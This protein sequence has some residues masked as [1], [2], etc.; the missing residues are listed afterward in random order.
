MPK[1]T[2]APLKKLAQDY[3]IQT[4]YF[5]DRK[6]RQQVSDDVLFALLKTLGA[7]IETEKDITGAFRE[8][9]QCQWQQ[10]LDPV[11]VAWEG[12]VPP[13]PLRLPLSTFERELGVS[14]HLENGKEYRW[15]IKAN[16]LTACG[17]QKIEGISYALKEL[18][19]PT[20]LLPKLPFGYHHLYLDHGQSQSR[21]LILSAPLKAYAPS[22]RGDRKDWGIFLPLYALQSSQSKGIGDFS[23]LRTLTDWVQQLGGNCVATLPLLAI[24]LDPIF[25]PSPYAPISRLFWN[26]L[27]TDL[28]EIPETK[29]CTK[30]TQYLNSKSVLEEQERLR[31]SSNVEY[32]KVLALK[33]PALAMLTKEFFKN[34]SSRREDFQQYLANHPELHDYARFR[35]TVDRRKVPWQKW[36]ERLQKGILTEEDY[37][38][39]TYQYHLYVQWIAAEQLHNIATHSRQKGQ[40]LYL[41]LPLGVHTGGYDVWKKRSAFVLDA[42]G[43]APPDSVFTKGQDWGFAPLH[44]KGIR[45][46]EYGYVRTFLQQHMQQAGILRIDHVMGLHRLYMIPRGMEAKQGAYVRYRPDEFYA[47]LCLESHRHRT[48]LVGENLGTVPTHINKSLRLHR[49]HPLYVVQ[50]ELNA[51]I[52]RPLRPISRHAIA[53]LNTHDMPP[54]AAYWKGLDIDDRVKMGLLGEN[55]ANREKIQRERLRINLGKFLNHSCELGTDHPDLIQLLNGSLDVLAQSK[56]RLTLINLED[57]WMETLSQNIP[58]SENQHPNWTRKAR[59][60]LEEIQNH[61]GMV[62]LLRRM[63]AHRHGLSP[64]PKKT[65]SRPDDRR[66]RD[67]KSS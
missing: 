31:L 55:D 43:G 50:Y 60:D 33:R 54:Y 8:S 34:Q 53:S 6:Q 22:H 16:D 5:D 61:H 10:P 67:R 66:A 56:A 9:Q 26:E 11:Q 2:S 38:Q 25:D 17:E 51:Q 37:D 57:G 12:I 52:N 18:K 35:A 14:L 3:D 58:A 64:S 48:M 20:H 19:I 65:E 62:E 7:P 1:F 59:F 41:D 13:L 46:E 32:Q 39:E 4:S 23:D 36:P 27:Y 28:S 15:S 47:I 40:G 24:W 44:P 30:V 63:N 49:L 29:T 45:Q 21:T 42:A